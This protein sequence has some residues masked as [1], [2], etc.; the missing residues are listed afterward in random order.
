[1]A[2]PGHNGDSCCY[3]DA[4][5]ISPMP[6]EGDRKACFMSCM[7]QFLESVLPGSESNPEGMAS[8]TMCKTL[9]GTSA[10]DERTFWPLYWCDM[11]YCGLAVDR[12]GNEGQDPN[13]NKIINNCNGIGVSTIL[14]SGPPPEGFSCSSDKAGDSTCNPP[15]MNKMG[16]T[17]AQE[18]PGPAP[19]TTKV[20]PTNPTAAHPTVSS[21]A[22]TD[23]HSSSS[24]TG[25]PLTTTESSGLSHG[26]K[27]AL[28]VCSVLG[29]LILVG[30]IFIFLRRRKRRKTQFRSALLQ[31]QLLGS[32]G[33]RGGDGM[34]F[35]FSGRGGGGD[36][37]YSPTPLISP[38]GSAVG[39]SINTVADPPLTP[40]LRLRDRRLL[41]PSI[42]RTSR[43]SDVS[44]PLTPLTPAYSPNHTNANNS[45][46]TSFPT[47]PICAPTV[48]KLVPR[49]ERTPTPQKIPIESLPPL[50]SSNG[51]NGGNGGSNS[52]RGSMITASN[53]S[54]TY[55]PSS[56][57][58]NSHTSLLRHEV[59]LSSTSSSASTVVP[60]HACSSPPGSPPRPPRPHDTPLEIPDLLSAAPA[61]SSM[62]PPPAFRGFSPPGPLPSPPPPPLAVSVS[63]PA[64]KSMPSPG[65]ASPG[66]GTFQGFSGPGSYFLRQAQRPGSP[67][68]FS[69]PFGAQD[70]PRSAG[71]ERK[72][73]SPTLATRTLELNL[74]DRATTNH[75]NKNTAD[76]DA[77]NTRGSWGSWDGT[78]AATPTTTSQGRATFA[79]NAGGDIPRGLRPMTPTATTIPTPTAISPLSMSFS[80]PRSPF[81]SGP[82]SPRLVSGPALSSG[83]G[84]LGSPSR[85][86]EKPTDAG[87]SLPFAGGEQDDDGSSASEYEYHGYEYGFGSGNGNGNGGASISSPYKAQGNGNGH[88]RHAGADPRNFIGGA[89]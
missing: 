26:A 35:P 41:L 86:Q 13:V 45:S 31:S 82:G 55:C 3:F 51:A 58:A 80:A 19:S 57:G 66:I 63:I 23:T 68:S 73:S 56:M 40:P 77:N 85:Q 36:G 22:A 7:A 84:V 8:T 69:S 79:N 44:P 21:K 16:P 50:A 29:L 72:A 89:F 78:P 52:R 65:P 81:Q 30:L 74:I 39:G 28:A 6:Q 54:A 49:H 14:D 64:P 37:G 71:G 4:A 34:F 25:A 70:V 17:S 46:A 53:N 88:D 20:I 61:T 42:L 38:A 47:S 5:N 9:N 27:I 32:T 76:D 12:N 33:G 24:S 18:A 62:S 10:G 48:N 75:A 1:M 11:N 15:T 87:T 2:A 83:V 67:R 43:S 60:P 59:T